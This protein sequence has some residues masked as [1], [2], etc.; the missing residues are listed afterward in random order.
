MQQSEWNGKTHTCSSLPL[1]LALASAPLASLS[2]AAPVLCALL[3]LFATPVPD[4]LTCSELVRLPV[5]VGDM[6]RERHVLIIDRFVCFAQA[7]ALF[8]RRL[9]SGMHKS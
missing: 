1:P 4:R 6:G 3:K 7:A 2:A 8:L 5:R 9:P